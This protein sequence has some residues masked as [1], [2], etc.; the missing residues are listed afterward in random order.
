MHN[1]DTNEISTYTIDNKQNVLE[2]YQL[3]RNTIYDNLIEEEKAY[4]ENFMQRLLST[5]DFNE[6]ILPGL[7]EFVRIDN[8]S[9]DFDPKWE[10]NGKA[11]KALLRRQ[12]AS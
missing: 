2:E 9:P 11:E 4:I 10:T 8:L 1:L 12:R 3:L 7:E 6:N 5:K